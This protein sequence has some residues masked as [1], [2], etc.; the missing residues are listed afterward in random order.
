MVLTRPKMGGVGVGQQRGCPPALRQAR[1]YAGQH[2]HSGH[3][4]C[5]YRVKTAVVARLSHPLRQASISYAARGPPGLPH[6]CRRRPRHRN[7]S[8]IVANWRQELPGGD[9][10]GSSKGIL[11]N[12]PLPNR[13]PPLKRS[14]RA[15]CDATERAAVRRCSAD[16]SSL[17]VWEQHK[18]ERHKSCGGARGTGVGR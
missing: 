5:G 15:G 4:P 3:A 14:S 7:E 8:D 12:C 11:V 13:V 2:H 9:L 10:H 1:T 18:R 16:A 17:V 6:S